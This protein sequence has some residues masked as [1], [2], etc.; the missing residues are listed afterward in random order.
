MSA[1]EPTADAGRT[2]GNSAAECALHA[3][4]EPVGISADLPYPM[5]VAVAL[6]GL[7]VLAGAFAVAR[8]VSGP[9]PAPAAVALLAVAAVPWVLLFL[10]GRDPGPTWWFATLALVPPAV[11]GFG[12]WSAVPLGLGSD[13]ALVLALIPVLLVVMLYDGFTPRR[14]ALC[15]VAAAYAV[16]AV[17]ALLGALTGQWVPELTVVVT[18]HVGFAFGLLAGYAVRFSFQVSRELTAVREELARRQAAEERRRA[19]QDV[20][21]VVAHT[22]S[23]TMLHL[24]AARMAALRGEVPAAV[25]A[26]EDA[27]RQGRSSLTDIRRVVRLLRSPGETRT[28]AQPTLDDLPELVD[29]YRAAGIEV[30][31][32]VAT[33]TVHAPGAE[34]AAYRVAQEALTNAVRHGSGPARMR[35]ARERQALTLEV[36]NPAP[37]EAGAARQGTGLRG[38]AERVAAAGGELTTGMVDGHWRVRARLPL[39]AEAAERVG[40]AR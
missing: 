28:T 10:P 3:E 19:A 22:L 29:G 32:E 35:L 18:W 21:D 24:T 26:L 34:L 33:A 2:G 12:Q 11:L 31:A 36:S 8:L 27:E 40:A 14:R 16:A 1:V 20:H 7:A 4:L 9:G 37:A 30:D 25:E 17:P 15:A 38:M 39:P 5:R 13:L 23:V 6:L